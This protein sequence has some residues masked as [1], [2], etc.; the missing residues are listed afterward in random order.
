MTSV[1]TAL[2]L[3]HLLKISDSGYQVNIFTHS[4]ERRVDRPKIG[5]SMILGVCVAVVGSFG[6]IGN[7]LSLVTIATMM[8]KSLFNKLLLTLTI[9]DT[10]FISNAG[11]FMAQQSLNFKSEIYNYLF[12]T[13]IYP[14]AGFS[15]TGLFKYIFSNVKTLHRKVSKPKSKQKNCQESGLH[16]T[17]YYVR[18]CK[19]WPSFNH[20]YLDSFHSV[21]VKK[22]WLPSG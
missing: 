20:L 10:I 3:T 9:Y 12:P 15:M 7:L 2:R 16:S 5:I 13:V 6:L 1:G 21:C 8:K 11:L 19:Q 22:R 17:S 18:I 4:K 14:L